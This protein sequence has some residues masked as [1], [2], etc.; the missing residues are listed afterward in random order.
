[1]TDFGYPLGYLHY[2]VLST[3]PANKTAL[4]HRLGYVCYTRYASRQT[5]ATRE[6]V[7]L[8]VGILLILLPYLYTLFIATSVKV[9]CLMTAVGAVTTLDVTWKHVKVLCA[10]NRTVHTYHLAEYMFGALCSAR[11]LEPFIMFMHTVRRVDRT[12]RHMHH[13]EQPPFQSIVR[14]P[15]HPL[16]ACSA[17]NCPTDTAELSTALKMFTQWSTSTT[18]VPKACSNIVI[19]YPTRNTAQTQLSLKYVIKVTS[20]N[21]VL[22]ILP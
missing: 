18:V 22:P 15:P 4:G 7:S 10:Y 20:I 21:N 17:Q 13:Q 2:S 6:A 14:T 9:A 16:C 1:M 3:E 19:Y 12:Q 8:T 5:Y 11:P